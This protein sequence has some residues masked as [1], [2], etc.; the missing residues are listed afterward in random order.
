M[1]TIRT[2]REIR[3]RAPFWLGMLLFA[4][5]VIMAVDARDNVT[6]QRMVR[7]WAQAIASPVQSVSSKAGGASSGLIRQIINFRSAADENER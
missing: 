3:Q 1:A 2:Q 4:N 6:K 7:V 5:L